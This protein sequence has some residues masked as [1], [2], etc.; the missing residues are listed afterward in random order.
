MSLARFQLFGSTVKSIDWLSEGRINMG[1]IIL[2][3]FFLEVDHRTNYQQ[4][5]INAPHDESE[6]CEIGND[7]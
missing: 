4:D 1:T 2:P 7:V 3:A 6:D 5:D